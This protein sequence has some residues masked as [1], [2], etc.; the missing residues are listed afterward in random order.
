MFD[1]EAE[2]PEIFS[3]KDAKNYGF[4]A[5]IGNPPYIRIQAMREWAP[6]EVG[7]YG[8]HYK[9]ASVGNYDIYVIFVEKGLSILTEHGIL[10][11]ILPTKFF[12]T[13][14][15]ASLRKLISQKQALIEVVDFH[16][17]QIFKGSTTYTCLLFLN[18]RPTKSTLYVEAVPV[19]SNGPLELSKSIR[20]QIPTDSDSPWLFQS[21]EEENLAEKIM[22]RTRSLEELPTKISRGS[23]TGADDVFIFNVAGEHLVTKD[24]QNIAIEPEIL[25]IPIYATDFGRF[26]FQPANTQ[27]ILF[28]YVVRED[29]YQLIE[30]KVLKTEFPKA[31]KYLLSRKNDLLIRKQFRMWYSFSAPRSLEI[32]DKAQMLVPLLADRGLFCFLPSGGQKR[33]LMASAGFSLTLQ[34]T[35]LSQKYVLGL[36][37][38]K[39]LFWRLKSIS[40]VFRGGWITC[41]KQYVRTLPIRTIDFSDPADKSLHDKMVL[42]VERM[43]ALHKQLASARTEHEQTALKRQI[44]ATD[45][46]TDGLV[47]ELYG[48]T[49]EEIGIVEGKK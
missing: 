32:H 12:S 26:V 10:G 13:D 11:F 17:H 4:D 47:Y 24:G 1:W 2:F 5:V 19:S 44:D 40:N 18:G 45:R 23:S 8:Q 16:H 46:Q 33:C 7:W 42:L 20:T 43:L 15:G 22:S 37:N 36:L 29:G 25:R 34:D 28:P 9:A 49:E 39:L 6:V 30:E 35:D 31:Y 48:L 3:R 14:Y 38:S 27:R 21:Q 41:T